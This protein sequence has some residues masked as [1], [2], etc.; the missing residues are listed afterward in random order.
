M[1]RSFYITTLGCPKNVADS[2]EMERSLLSE[3]FDPAQSPAA[4][5]F[6]LINSCAFVEDARMETIQTVMEAAR[7]KEGRPGQR[8][9]LVGCFSE[10]YAA[11]VKNELPEVD[12]S[13]GTGRYGAAGEMLVKEFGAPTL[14]PVRRRVE[15]RSSAEGVGRIL[16][17]HGVSAPVKISDGCDRTCAFCAIPQF[18]GSFRSVDRAKIVAECRALSLEG[19]RELCLVSQDTNAYGGSPDALVDL[20]QELDEIDGIAWVRLLYLYPDKR[21]ERIL[22]KIQD[23]RLSKLVPYFESPIQHA[24]GRVLK[25]MNRAGDAS[26]FKDLFLLAREALPGAEIR[27]T[28][29]MGFPGE[30]QADVDEVLSFVETARPEKL[31]LFTYSPEEGTAGQV[32]TG[33]VPPKEA[34]ERVNAVRTAHLNILRDIHAARVGRVYQCIVDQIDGDTVHCRRPQDAPEIDEAVFV[35]VAALKSAPEPGQLLD[36]EI[37]GF[38]EYDMT[39]RPA[40]V[41]RV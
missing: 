1:A 8:L 20:L 2:R 25:A 15:E 27:T 31:A 30:T 32:M 7:V 13:F 35:P 18:R 28:F 14:V 34:A 9:V 29:L 39:A 26:F 33:V 11:E 21:T 22:R 41:E 3:G 6:H 40:I 24:S 16:R 4:A 23:K 5:D 36:L 10:R 12:Y 38:F 37:D 19:V 17:P